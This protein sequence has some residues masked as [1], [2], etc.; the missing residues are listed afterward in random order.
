MVYRNINT[1]NDT[2]TYP[3]TTI[4]AVFDEQTGKPLTAIIR[5][6]KD[7]GTPTV[8]TQPIDDPDK[9]IPIFDNEG[10]L[11]QVDE[12]KGDKLLKS[13]KINYN[14]GG[15]IETVVESGSDNKTHRIEYKDD[16]IVSVS[17]DK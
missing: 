4:D 13:T 12:Y 5:D 11:K 16:N 10:R 3:I 1:G 7:N 8:P 14:K 15:Q 6:L 17:V 9:S 2:V